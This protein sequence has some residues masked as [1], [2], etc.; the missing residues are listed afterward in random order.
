M[1]ILDLL[2]KQERRMSIN[3]RGYI[4][5]KIQKQFTTIIHK[6]GVCYVQN[7]IKRSLD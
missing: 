2:V 1:K 5:Y 3:E 7:E 6:K 4:P